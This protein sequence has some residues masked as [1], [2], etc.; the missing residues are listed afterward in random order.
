[1]GLSTFDATG[2][3]AATRN[4]L[5]YGPVGS[6]KTSF[7]LSFLHEGL[8]RG[9]S[10]ALVTR[11]HPEVVLEQAR[12]LGLALDSH[13]ESGTFSILEY[14]H[15]V[16]ENVSRLK[17]EEEVVEELERLLAPDA[18]ADPFPPGRLVFDP[19]S[20]LLAASG[21]FGSGGR[22][23][24]SHFSRIGATA[25][26][27]IELPEGE[28]D[29]TLLREWAHAVLRFEPVGPDRRRKALR[30]ERL[31]GSPQLERVDFEV[32]PGRGLAPWVARE[33]RPN[34]RR[35][36]LVIDPRA[37]EREWLSRLFEESCDVE[38]VA[39][40][41]SGLAAM[42]AA[43]PDLI[44]VAESAGDMEGVALCKRLR[45]RDHNVPLVLLSS[46]H[47]R[48]R[49]RLAV[50]GMGADECLETPIDGRLLRVKVENLLRRYDGD[51]DRLRPSRSGRSVSAAAP[52]ADGDPISTTDPDVFLERLD[53]AAA[54]CDRDGVPFAV[55]LVRR[56]P[57]GALPPLE[58]MLREYD[59]TCALEAVAL[60]L[61][62]ETGEQGVERFLSRLRKATEV[63]L[64]TD[65]HCYD[66][67]GDGEAARSVVEG[68][69][70]PAAA[71]VSGGGG[72]ACS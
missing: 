30:P 18:G 56:P 21:P 40:A 44:L 11:S 27:L 59:A 39:D 62:A 24:V 43:P 60:V 65:H 70:R 5:A 37:T 63:A 55:V 8:A 25:L 29:V 9:E 19:V 20:P 72:R 48:L 22:R 12:S 26:Y 33:A 14:S 68:W 15:D 67:P 34:L 64:L 31:F 61:L 47:R 42:A 17:D 69:M 49:D 7:A 28:A 16:C 23:V 58:S 54:D 52:A 45:D 38:G 46:G 1:V 3:L 50:L 36:L 6:G 66:T 32:V 71:A 10:A 51:R 35:R 2:G 41:S 4:H 13:L 53:G 57:G